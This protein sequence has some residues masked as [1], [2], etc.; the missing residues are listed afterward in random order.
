MWNQ[1]E[2]WNQ[3]R[4]DVS[5]ALNA[6]EDAIR[7]YEPDQA[8]SICS[9]LLRKDGTNLF[10]LEALSRALWQAGR[11]GEVV[12]A[13]IRMRTLNPRDPG[14]GYVVGLAQQAL[15][16]YGEAA[17]SMIQAMAVC[18]NPALAEKIEAAI[19]ELDDLQRYCV[20]RLLSSNDHFRA[21]FAEDSVAACREH[22]IA[23]SWHIEAEYGYKIS[24]RLSS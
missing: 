22:G 21:N 13:G 3:G 6:A 7:A 16:N 11:F 2:L 18:S 17:R 23:F 10:A 1:S 4:F 15:G 8:I 19:A 20:Q 24:P 5:N 12:E 9:V 14:Y